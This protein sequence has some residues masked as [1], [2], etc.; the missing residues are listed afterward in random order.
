VTVTVARDGTVTPPGRIARLVHG[1]VNHRKLHNPQT[2]RV[3][4]PVPGRFEVFVNGVSGWGGAALR[5]LV[6]G[7]PVLEKEFADP[8][9]GA[10]H[11]TRMEYNGAYGV[12]IP[13]GKH[14]ITL[15]NPGKDWFTLREI[16]LRSYDDAPVGVRALALRG[17]ETALVWLRTDRFVWYASLLGMP[18]E[19][20]RDVV[21]TLPGF[22]PG[23]WRVRAFNLPGGEARMSSRVTVRDG[24]G[25]LRIVLGDVARAA[26]LRLVRE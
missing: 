14:T 13:A 6:D 10:G 3:D 19:P 22:T 16:T 8:D 5:I 7:E 1:M 23:V 26:V 25:Q 9:G 18:R 17:R 2:F 20:A 4:Y 24:D 11:E 12:A 21:L 15:E